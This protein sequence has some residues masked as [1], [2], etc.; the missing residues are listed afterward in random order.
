[1]EKKMQISVVIPMYREAQR[2]APHLE[3]ILVY[4]SRG[5]QR[6]SI[7]EVILVDDASH[8]STVEVCTW[9]TH[10]FEKFVDFKIL[11]HEVNA[12]KWAAIRTGMKASNPMSDYILILD[13][14]GSAS[15]SNLD[16]FSIAKIDGSVFGT[17][18]S[19]YSLVRNKSLMRI[20][21]SRCYKIYVLTMYFLAS[22]R[23]DVSDMQCPWKLVPRSIYSKLTVDR[24]A[25]D[26]EVAL[27]SDKISNLPIEFT[28]AQGSS[29]SLGSAFEM[30]K[31]VLVV[32]W[33]YRKVL[34]RGQK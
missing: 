9:F 17:R 28:H 2:I 29:I 26:L 20:L 15:I 12:G 5:R 27:Y 7:V 34:S 21:V 16:A 19:K 1:M 18:F 11:R 33:R 3:E 32:A 25:G 30:A 31:D 22:G 10:K 8:D 14:D 24:F 23:L 13:A 4:L 6:K